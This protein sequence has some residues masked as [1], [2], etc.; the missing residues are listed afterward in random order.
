MDTMS[1]KGQTTTLEERVTIADRV[2][3]GKSSREIAEE[4]GRP[5]STVRKWRQ[6]YL[7]EGRAGLSSQMGR[8][9]AG[10]LAKTPEEM[11]DALL[12]MRA[13]H[14]GWGP[15]TLRL[16][17]AKDVRFTGLTIPSR[18]RIAAYLKERKKARKYERHQDLPEPKA[19]PVQ[20]A[21]QEW[22]MDAQGVTEVAGLGKFPSSTFAMFTVVSVSTAMLA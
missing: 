11:K 6:R 2:L 22:E 17:I 9:A 5:P 15:Q 14:P 21:H 20:R 8:P 18:A 12:D 13:Q 10:A 7:R 1:H 3:A 16:E 19:E 4:L